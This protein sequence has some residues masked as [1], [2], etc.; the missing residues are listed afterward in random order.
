MVFED[1]YEVKLDIESQQGEIEISD[2]HMENPCKT[3]NGNYTEH[4]FRFECREGEI[5]L[6]ATGFKMQVRK[7]PVLQQGQSLEL[8]ERGGVNF[9]RKLNAL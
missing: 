6:S 5:S 8:K 3:K 9:G 2:L 7:N 1:V 4:T